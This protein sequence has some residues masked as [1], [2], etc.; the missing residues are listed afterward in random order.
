[1]MICTL[2]TPQDGKKMCFDSCTVLLK[3][4]SKKISFLSL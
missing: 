2:N 4:F 3:C 1:M